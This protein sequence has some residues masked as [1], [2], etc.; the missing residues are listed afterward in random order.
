MSVV[1]STVFQP[2]FD[3][4]ANEANLAAAFRLVSES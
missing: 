3:L 4:V 1:V 2:W